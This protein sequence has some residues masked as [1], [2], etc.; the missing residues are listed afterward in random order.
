MHHIE[1]MTL[2]L[3]QKYCKQYFKQ[4][5]AIL[6]QSKHHITM[7]S[8]RRVGCIIQIYLVL[9]YMHKQVEEDNDLQ[10]LEQGRYAT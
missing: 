8:V 5:S 10:T 6:L 7:G 3:Q 2:Q 9:R 1:Q 4:F